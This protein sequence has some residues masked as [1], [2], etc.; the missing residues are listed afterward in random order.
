M[1]NPQK[2]RLQR[3]YILEIPILLVAVVLGLSFLL[4]HLSPVARK[5]LAGIA[6]FPVLFCLYYMI[7]TPGWQPDTSS[8]L[9]PP[10]NWVVFLLVAA[11][12][13]TIAVM[14]ILT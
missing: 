4:P 1:R 13:V 6:V 8:R 14:F 9:K 2:R 10:W 12:I 5:V 7:V 3:G 11:V